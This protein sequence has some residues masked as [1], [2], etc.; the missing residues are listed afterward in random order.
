[1][2]RI[3]VIDDDPIICQMCSAYLTS[4]GHTVAV[5]RDGKEGVEK[6]KSHDFDLIITDLMMPRMHGYQA[7]DAIKATSKG[8]KIPVILLTADAKEADLEEFDRHHFQ[9]DTLSKP[10]DMPDLE[11]MIGDLMDEFADRED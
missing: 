1:M 11:K 2:S 7:I 8:Q 5:A 3:L 10:F 6:F 9:D 4:L